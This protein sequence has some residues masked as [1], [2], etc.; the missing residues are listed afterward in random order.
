MRCPVGAVKASALA[1][2]QSTGDVVGFLLV[3]FCCLAKKNA[4]KLLRTVI[5]AA[6][7]VTFPVRAATSVSFAERP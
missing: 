5:W 1:S 6:E 4:L 7:Q 3:F 2:A